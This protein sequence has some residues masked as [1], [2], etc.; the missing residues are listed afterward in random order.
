MFGF[1]RGRKRGQLAQ[2]P[3]PEEWRQ[4]LDEHVAFW[5]RCPEVLTEKYL[6]D[7]KVFAWEKHWF[8]AGGLEMT[9]EIK[10]VVSAAAARLI[11]HLDLG[12]YDRL[13]E[14]VVYPGAYKHPDNEHAVILGEAHSFGTVVLAWDA[15]L[16][17]LADP[18]DGH[19]TAT[20]EFAH[21]LDREGGEFNGTPRLATRADYRPWAEV[22]S[23]HFFALQDEERPEQKVLRDYGATN[24]AEFFAV[25]T[26]SFFEK[27]RQMRTHTPELYDVLRDFYGFDPCG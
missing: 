22:M 2:R 6:S 1:F 16:H 7:L 9:D 13:T 3:F 14:I 5:T 4:Y 24:E 21:V 12:Y 19:D 20:H 17:G 15:V 26:E 8:G 27:P 10:V 11:L 18:R 23:R 25:A